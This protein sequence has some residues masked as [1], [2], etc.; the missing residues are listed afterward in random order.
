[1]TA[2]VRLRERAAFVAV[3]V[4]H[5]VYGLLFY[6]KALNTF[7]EGWMV[8]AAERIADGQVPYRDF[9]LHTT[10]ASY[11]ILAALYELFGPSLIVG[12]L[13]ALVVTAVT[14]LL[15]YVLARKTASKWPALAAA[16][17]Y[18][19]WSTGQWNVYWYTPV[20]FL[21]GLFALLGVARHYA[22]T[23]RTAL[24]AAGVAVAGAYAA[25][26]NIGAAL[27][28][29]IVVALLVNGRRNLRGALASVAAFVSGG[30][31]ATTV[32][33]AMLAATGALWDWH[34]ITSVVGAGVVAD[35][36]V[37]GPLNVLGSLPLAVLLA[38]DAALL[39]ALG[40]RR[41]WSGSIVVKAAA[42]AVV[43]ANLA[44]PLLAEMSDPTRVAYFRGG[45]FEL[46]VASSTEIVV[47]VLPLLLALGATVLAVADLRRGV[48]PDPLFVTFLVV[49]PV[50]FYVSVLT[51]IDLVHLLLGGPLLWLLLPRVA[52]R[53][54]A[55]RR[56]G[57]PILDRDRF[58]RLA[59]GAGVALVAIAGHVV[60]RDAFI[61]LYTLAKPVAEDTYQLSAERGKG[62]ETDPAQGEAVDALISYIQ[63]RTADGEP[64]FFFPNEP[65][66]YF[67]TG[68]SNP[69]FY[70]AFFP[71]AFI[72]GDE[73]KVIAAL[74]SSGVRYVVLRT[75]RTPDERH[76]MY[77][78]FHQA[79]V[80]I[81]EFVQAR[82]RQ[83]AQFGDYVVLRKQ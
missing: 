79:T 28:L 58:Q 78:S 40:G 51:S 70:N 33:L 4:V 16:L 39:C 66:L 7:D 38:C 15:L 10:P 61:T 1:M 48:D 68:R 73:G 55:S 59:L 23:G 75:A 29:G 62:I 71:N 19:F 24:V 9:F 25:K 57:E 76:D 80:P 31:V 72:A 81:L 41:F 30:V 21:F 27:A 3:P 53:L 37:V 14:A 42:A 36:F 43:A 35:S 50:C 47:R 11:Y 63:P 56:F 45:P 52:E 8:Y 6:D 12:R 77:R 49:A 69:T 64:V 20:A 5:V 54:T 60:A 13:A 32:L 74:D 67:L 17:C 44:I 83:E 34:R 46:F 65:S 2:N 82:F 22:S 18:T 26:Q